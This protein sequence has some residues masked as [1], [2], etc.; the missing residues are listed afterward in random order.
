M[1]YKSRGEDLVENVK[2]IADTLAE[3]KAKGLPRSLLVIWVQKK[4]RLSQKDIISVFDALAEIEKE[5][6]K[7]IQ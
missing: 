3:L 2:R 5:F 7:P 6:Q 1:S 4:T